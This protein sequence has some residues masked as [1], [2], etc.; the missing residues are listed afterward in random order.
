ME[1]TKSFA[2]P[3]LFE[4]TDYNP[5]GVCEWPLHYSLQFEQIVRN[6]EGRPVP[7]D[8]RWEFLGIYRPWTGVRDGPMGN[9]LRVGIV[10]FLPT[11]SSKETASIQHW[12]STV[13]R[14]L[15]AEP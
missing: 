12:N 11:F 2:A 14:T 10:R 1:I 5:K 13:G 3:S 9:E 4:Y 7:S 15:S 8:E 6:L